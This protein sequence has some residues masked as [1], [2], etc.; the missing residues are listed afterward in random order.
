[1]CESDVKVVSNTST[2]SKK[3]CEAFYHVL[4]LSKILR[5]SKIK[6]YVCKTATNSMKFFDKVW[7]SI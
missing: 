3:L 7:G 6:I 5:F 1:M 2:T 4:V